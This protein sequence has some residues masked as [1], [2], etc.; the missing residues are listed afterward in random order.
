MDRI[1]DALSSITASTAGPT[2]MSRAAQMLAQPG[3][4]MG[5]AAPAAAPSFSNVLS[6]A[7]QSVQKLQSESSTLQKAYQQGVPEVGLEQTMIAM[8]KSSIA[9][10]ML[11]QARNRVVAAYNEVMSM[12]V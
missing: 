2:G 7:I 8:N 3:S 11:A 12:P 6:D 4:L 9:F 10:Q 1:Q 5:G